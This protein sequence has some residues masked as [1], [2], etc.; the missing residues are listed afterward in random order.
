MTTEHEM[1]SIQILEPKHVKNPRNAF[2]VTCVA[3]VGDGD[4]YND[5]RLIPIYRT[6]GY[7]IQ[8]AELVQ[9]F[10]A[11]KNFQWTSENSYSNLADFDKWF[12]SEDHADNGWSGGN[13]FLDDGFVAV[14]DSYEIIYCDEDGVEHEVSIAGRE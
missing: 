14:L 3:V 12:P 6:E 7:E 4:A 5:I 9:L 2:V 11:M 10:D 8:I 13:P 1:I